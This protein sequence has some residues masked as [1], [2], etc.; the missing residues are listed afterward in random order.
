VAGLQPVIDEALRRWAIAESLD[1]A[2]LAALQGVTFEIADLPGLALGELRGGS[3][4]LDVDAAGHGWFV[5]TTPRLDQEFVRRSGEFTARRGSD[6]AGRIDLLSVVAH[7]LG[8]ALGL[9]HAEAG[10]MDETLAAGVRVAP[11]TGYGATTPVATGQGLVPEAMLAALESALTWPRPA[12][13]PATAPVIDW[14]AR[15]KPLPLELA[16][17][18][19]FAR[20]NPDWLADFVINAGQTESQRDPN[21][22]I[23]L[24]VPAAAKL[25]I[26]NPGSK[27]RGR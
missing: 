6:A 19:P 4:V 21:A 17:A 25:G 14:S 18:S 15:V 12:D 11:A 22:K 23:R 2:E 9:E 24:T 20:P 10:V 7:E 13:I 5:D 3:V 27:L 26:L 16:T 1:D 8:H